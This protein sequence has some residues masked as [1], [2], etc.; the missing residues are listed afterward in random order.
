MPSTKRICSS[1][2]ET[3]YAQLSIY[4]FLR[5]GGGAMTAERLD[6]SDPD[7]LD[8]PYPVLADLRAEAPLVW[9]EAWGVWL[10]TT[11]GAVSA[12]L[13]DRRFGRIWSRSTLCIATR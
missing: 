1:D 9:H 4:S 11:H 5:G 13:R 12:V 6:T 8:D 3:R 7:F 10:A 2:E